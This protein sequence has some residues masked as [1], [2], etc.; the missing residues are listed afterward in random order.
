M[1]LTA[2]TVGRMIIDE[3]IERGFKPNVDDGSVTKNGV[4]MQ[5]VFV[6]EKWS[7]MEINADGEAHLPPHAH[8]AYEIIYVLTGT[9]TITMHEEPPV[10]RTLRTGD[11]YCVPE[12][13]LHSI[14]FSEPTH[15]LCA[16]HPPI[17][18]EDHV[19]E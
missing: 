13:V 10:H 9:C 2:A 14:N 19:T 5:T 15:L 4:R 18:V 6:H 8:D 7:V 1:D 3:Y 12:N 16:F 17:R 11:K